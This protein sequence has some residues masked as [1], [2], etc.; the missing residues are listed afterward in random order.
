MIEKTPDPLVIPEAMKT[1]VEVRSV[2]VLFS[3]P[4]PEMV[5]VVSDVRY[6]GVVSPPM[7]VRVGASGIPVSTS[8]ITGVE[9]QFGVTELS[10]AET[11]S[12]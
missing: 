2:T 8:R 11:V 6:A 7:L 12:V 10:Q 9:E 4:V 3:S 1:P 5:G